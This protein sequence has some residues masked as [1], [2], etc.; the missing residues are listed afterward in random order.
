MPVTAGGPQSAAI[1]NLAPIN[2]LDLYFEVH[3][4][5]RPLVLLHGGP[6]TI[7]L[8]FGR[9]IPALAEGHQ[10]IGVEL[11]GHGHTVDIDRPMSL[12]DLAGDVASLVDHLAIEEADFLG[13]SLGSMVEIVLAL[14]RPDLVGKLVPWA[15]FCGHRHDPEASEDSVDPCLLQTVSS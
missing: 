9:L 13:F 3:G 5:G 7:D 11:Q 15:T 12:Q 2:G 1:G 4:T 10:V 6:L 14:R 8:I